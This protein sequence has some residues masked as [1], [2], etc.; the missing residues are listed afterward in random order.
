MLRCGDENSLCHP[1]P[2]IP[3]QVPAS[4]TRYVVGCCLPGEAG[5]RLE[6]RLQ[7][8][9]YGVWTFP[10]CSNAVVTE[11]P[12]RSPLSVM[13]APHRVYYALNKYIKVSS[14]GREEGGEQR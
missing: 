8:L 4:E 6:R 2:P 13:V 3:G 1:P 10:E 14:S 5:N 11:F 7:S 12:N 9:G